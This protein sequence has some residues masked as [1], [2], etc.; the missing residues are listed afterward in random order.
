[1]TTAY[2]VPLVYITNQEFIDEQVANASDILN[3]Q[4]TQVKSAAGEHTSRLTSSAKSYASEYTTKAQEYVGSAKPKAH[5]PPPAYGEK[6]FPAAPKAEPA[7]GVK[8][9]EPIAF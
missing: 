5:S 7:P 8:S 4:A 6:D 9:E 2:F 3:K 1:M